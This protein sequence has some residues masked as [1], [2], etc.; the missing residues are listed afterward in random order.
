MASIVQKLK[1]FFGSIGK[2]VS[3]TYYTLKG[4]LGGV[5]SKKTAT[6]KKKKAAVVKAPAAAP[7][8]APASAPVPAP[9]PAASAPAAPASPTQSAGRKPRAK[10]MRKMK[11]Y[12]PKTRKR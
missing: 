8:P 7:A 12:K 2:G 1:G 4:T 10:N 9:A 3:N 11:F 5:F 6:R